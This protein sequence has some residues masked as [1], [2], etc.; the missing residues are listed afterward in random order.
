MPV[1][2]TA[3]Q[4]TISRSDHTDIGVNST[5]AA[6]SLEFFFLKDSH[7][8]H[9][10]FCCQLADFIE[11]DR[12]AMGSFEPADPLLQRSGERTLFV[13]EQLARDQFGRKCCAIHFNE[14]PAGPRCSPMNRMSD[15]FLSGAGFPGYQDC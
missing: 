12:S 14:S 8:C 15:E 11:K 4:V 10:R 13:A 1:R 9:L 7:Q 6:Y 5:V 3:L 2:N